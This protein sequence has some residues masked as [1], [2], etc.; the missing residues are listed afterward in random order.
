[1]PQSQQLTAV[2]LE[3]VLAARTMPAAPWNVMEK[4]MGQSVFT[5]CAAVGQGN[6]PRLRSATIPNPMPVYTGSCT[7]RFYAEGEG[8]KDVEHGHHRVTERAVGSRRRQVPAA[9][10]EEARDRHDV[11]QQRCERGVV[12]QIVVLAAE[13]EQT[14]PSAL[15]PQSSG[16]HAL[17]AQLTGLLEEQAILRHG[18]AQAWT[19]EHVAVDATEGAHHDQSAITH[20]ALSPMITCAA[21][22]PTGSAARAG[23]HRS[24]AR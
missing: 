8:A 7:S 23:C 10:N 9:E 16:G 15:Q 3:Q 22:V 1:M 19:D 20:T 4:D 2:D 12:E 24:A 14:A 21:A 5:R 18:V 17:A 11:A 13:A 6:T